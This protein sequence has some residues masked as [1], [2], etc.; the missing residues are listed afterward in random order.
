MD[1]NKSVNCLGIDLLL[2]AIYYLSL[3]VYVVF[4]VNPMPI[5]SL[6]ETV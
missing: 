2:F 5:L 6:E 1:L 3:M 4:D